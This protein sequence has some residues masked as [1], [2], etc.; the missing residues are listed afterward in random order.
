MGHQRGAAILSIRE[1]PIWPQ[2]IRGRLPVSSGSSVTLRKALGAF[3]FPTVAMPVA[4]PIVIVVVH[5]EHLFEAQTGR[6]DAVR[7]KQVTLD[8]VG[9]RGP[10]AVYIPLGASDPRD[11][12]GGL[13]GR[14]H[15]GRHERCL[16]NSKNAE[17]GGSTVHA[18]KLLWDPPD[19]MIL[20]R[21]PLPESLVSPDPASI[22]ARSI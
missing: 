9:T 10:I 12:L 7:R 21:N 13:F 18:G 22:S 8:G 14:H 15:K 4:P 5:G 1:L 6:I 3:F 17:E 11:G 16:G 20:A 2:R 19:R